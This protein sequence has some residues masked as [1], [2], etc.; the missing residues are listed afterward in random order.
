MSRRV[1]HKT[2]LATATQLMAIDWSTFSMLANSLLS[3][4]SLVVVKT[5]NFRKE[6]RD[7]DSV[8]NTPY[9]RRTQSRN[10]KNW[11]RSVNEKVPPNWC[12]LFRNANKCHSNPSH[13]MWNA[14]SFVKLTI[15]LFA[16]RR[17]KENRQLK[18]SLAQPKSRSPF[19]PFSATLL[20]LFCNRISSDTHWH[21]G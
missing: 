7:F 10:K 11:K 1:S 20:Q 15:R 2:T 17:R 16:R 18:K 19:W 14:F 5:P 6:E 21:T 4:Q 3:S 9:H 8:Q 13:S 12:K